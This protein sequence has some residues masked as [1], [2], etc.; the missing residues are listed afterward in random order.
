MGNRHGTSK[1]AEDNQN[2]G[3]FFHGNTPLWEVMSVLMCYRLGKAQDWAYFCSMFG[4]W[5]K[6]Q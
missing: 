4:K 3:E 6:N 1:Q 2:A 5:N